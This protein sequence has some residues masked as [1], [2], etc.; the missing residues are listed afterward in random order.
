MFEPLTEVPEDFEYRI[1]KVPDKDSIHFWYKPAIT[2]DTLRLKVVSPKRTD[3]LLT[4][5]TDMPVDSLQIT[6]EPSGAIDFGANAI[7]RANTPI[8]EKDDALISIIDKDSVSVNFTSEIDPFQN[9]IQLKFDKKENQEYRLTLLP[10]AVTDFYNASNDT[11]KKSFTTRALSEYGNLTFN[12]QNVKS[13]PVIV[14]LT[15]EK[16]VVKAEQYSTSQSNLR[17]EFLTP[18]KYFARVIFDQNENRLWDTGNFLR[19][20]KPEEIIYFPVILDIRPNWDV[21]ETF[22]VN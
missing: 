15:D 18:G 13:F 7:L 8:I 5:I 14:Q 3:T 2:G 16:G 6:T 11:I 10:G 17:F 4:R 20:E 12:L 9:T 19:N 22:N 1:T 21:N